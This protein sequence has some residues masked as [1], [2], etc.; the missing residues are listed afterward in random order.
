M[1]PVD[2]GKA[3]DAVF[4]KY[5]D[6]LPYLEKRIGAYCSFCEL[7]I[8]HVPEIEHREARSQ[9]GEE[10]E[11]KNLLLS[12]KYCNTRKGTIVKAGDEEKYL[13]PDRDDTFH[14]FSYSEDIPKLNEEYLAKAGDEI[15]DRAKKLYEVLKL[16]H[17]PIS[18][19]DKDRR[20]RARSEA[21]NQAL[22]SREGWEEIKHTSEKELFFH[23]IIMLAKATGFFSVWMEIFK[24]D[25]EITSGLI[26]AFEGTRKELLGEMSKDR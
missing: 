16:D 17:I 12:C 13:W 26:N 18:I 11:W 25:K 22:L 6:A 8:Q 15:R 3:P 4:K 21:R 9:G 20:Y 23:Q 7:H 19:K 5:Q 2:K 24:S 14:V 10:L 1:R